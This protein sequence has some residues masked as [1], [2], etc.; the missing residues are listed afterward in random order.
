MR[1]TLIH[2]SEAGDGTRPGRG[3]LE[4]LITQAGHEI[5]YQ[6][7]QEEGWSKALKSKTDLIAVAG[8]DGTVG[9]VARCTIG[10]RVPIAVLPMGTANNVSRTLGIADN[11]IQSLIASWGDGRLLPFDA[12][13]A[14][15]PWGERY[16]VEALGVG[17][18]PRSIPQIEA[19]ATLDQ[20]GD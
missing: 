13:I 16:F 11:P 18:F 9:Q 2:N 10:R 4:A 8:G 1:V 12:G 17:L 15:G 5:R 6:S 7:V 14:C 3:H 19:S 20:I